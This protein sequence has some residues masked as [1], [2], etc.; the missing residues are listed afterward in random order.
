MRF[1]T[2]RPRLRVLLLV[3]GLL[4]LVPASANAAPKKVRISFTTTTA[5]VN[6]NAGTYNLRVQ[7][8][9]NTRVTATVNLG[10][11]PRPQRWRATTTRSPAPAR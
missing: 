1:I 11:M 7:R 5:S 2:P 9:G 6:E 10:V 4:A 3:L 8:A